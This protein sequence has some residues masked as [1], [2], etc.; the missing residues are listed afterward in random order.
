MIEGLKV[1]LSGTK[2]RSLCVD[3]AIHHAERAT[4]YEKQM[5]AL[6]ANKIEGMNYSGGDPKRALSDK[7]EEHRN[8]SAELTFIAE[9][10]DVEQEYL[11][12][13][14]ALQKLGVCK[15]RGYW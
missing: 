14:A 11:L 12:D 2:L 7:L 9:H 13:R 8:E 15:A 5:E 1:T 3:Q 6:E 10:L 4:A